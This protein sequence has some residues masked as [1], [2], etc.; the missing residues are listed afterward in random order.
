M[1][2]LCPPKFIFRISAILYLLTF[3][4]QAFAQVPQPCRLFL[5]KPALKGASVSF[6]VKEVENGNILYSYEAEKEMTPA[7]V[8]KTVTTATAL[9]ILGEDFR[10]ETSVLYDGEIKD[11]VLNGNLY[12]YGSGDPTLN[13]SELESEKDSILI[14]WTSAIKQAGIQR[15]AGHVIADESVFDT[16]GVSMKWMR[17]DMGSSYGQGSYGLNIF[18]NR[19]SLYLSTGATGTQP[20]LLYTEPH[21]P[22]L[23]FYN[24]LKAAPTP[25]DSSYIVGVPFSHE[26]YLYGSIRTNQSRARITGDMPDPP[27]FLA[28]YFSDYLTGADIEID[29]SPSSY[30]LLSLTSEWPLTERKHL[31][32]TFSPPLKEIVRITNFTSHNLFADVMLKT[33]GLRY[34]SNRTEVVS[35]FEK[36]VRIVKDYWMG[37]NINTASLWMFDGSGLAITDKVTV[38][39]LCDL[40]IYMATKSNVSGAYLESL[41]QPGIEGTVRNMLRGSALQGRARLKSGSMSRVLCYG[42]YITKNG[43]QYAIALLV[44]NYSGRQNSLRGEI[45]ELLLALF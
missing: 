34:Q 4:F 35:S 20:T 37:K 40:Y 12:L 24:Y 8:M 13:S 10:F 41:P 30:R 31:I 22:S 9:E 42:G 28:Q 6:M 19:Y 43:K 27:L 36:G 33:L 3:N 45:E 25:L 21:L 26:R 44:N 11:G 39:F 15:I 2:A 18:D 23:T 32:T 38:D 17:E 5:Q 14:L 7:S 16:E 1:K 29:K